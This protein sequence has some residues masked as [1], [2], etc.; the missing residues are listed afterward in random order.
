MTNDGAQVESEAPL[1]YVPPQVL[2]WTDPSGR[3]YASQVVTVAPDVA[4]G[5]WNVDVEFRDDTMVRLDI[6]TEVA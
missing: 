1:G 6:T 3:E 4:D 2:A 5:L